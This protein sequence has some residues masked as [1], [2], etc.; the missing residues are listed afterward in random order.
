MVVAGG[1]DRLLWGGGDFVGRSH[2][3]R[4]DCGRRGFFSED[5]L[6]LSEIVS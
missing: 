4:E 1:L 2:G 5:F 3:V 6:E